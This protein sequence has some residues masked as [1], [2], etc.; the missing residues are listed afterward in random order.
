MNFDATSSWVKLNIG[1]VIYQTTKTTLMKDENSMLAKMFSQ[2]SEFMSPGKLDDNGCY[3]IDRNGRYFEAILNYLRT[4][5]LIYESN[6]NINGLLEE[7]KFFNIQ[8][9][10]VRLQQLADRSNHGIDDNAPLTRQDVVRALTQTSYKCELRFQGVNMKN[11][12]L[13]RLDLR[14]INFKYA[15]LSYC[16]LSYCNLSFCNL[17]RADLSYAFM[18]NAQLLG[19]KGL[20]ANMEGAILS[21]CNFEDPSGVRSNLEGCNLKGANLENSN[22]P[23][24]NLRV[25]SLKGAN[26]KNCILRSAILAGADLERADLS[27]SDLQEAN[28]RGT[29]LNNANLE[30]MQNPLHMS[31]AI[32]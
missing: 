25:A 14:N 6:L 2:D 11:A 21:N 29:N 5:E 27:G 19:I 20:C 32:R 15:N 8:E 28:L 16:N 4:G 23:C 9:M 31:Q 10:I 3:L 24:V 13:S 30:L 18:D 26:L 7:A 17:E 12:N 22:A 1:G